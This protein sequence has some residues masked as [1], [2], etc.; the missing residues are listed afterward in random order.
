V[1]PL[2]LELTAFG[3]YER[4]QAID[5]TALGPSELFL[6]HGPTG[7]GKTTLFDGLTYALFG[8]LAGTRGVD[9]L[10][11][12]RAPADLPTRVAFRFRLGETAYRVERTPEWQR[13]KKRGSGTTTE[14]ATASLWREGEAKP[15]ATGASDT[16][17]AVAGL[18]GMGV[19]QF[20][21]VAL[22]P[23]GEFKRLLCATTDEREALLQQLFATHRYAEVEDL[24]VG[25]KRELESKASKLKERRAEVLGGDAEEGLATAL[26]AAEAQVAEAS[27]GDAARQAEDRDAEQALAAARALAGRFEEREAARAADGRAR[28]G[29][30]ALSAD[31]L[32]LQRAEAAE[33]ARQRLEAARR[34]AEEEGARRREVAGGRE[35]L[36]AADRALAAAAEAARAAEAEAPERARLVARAQVLERALPEVERLVRLD[37]ELATASAGAAAAAAG[38][39]EAG[40]RL[41]AAERRPVELEEEAS[42]LRPLA[43][44]AAPRAEALARLERAL[45]AA[46]ERDAAEAASAVKAKEVAEAERAAA[47]ARE[48]AGRAEQAASALNAAREGGLAAWLAQ[49]KL[50]PGK[51]CPVCGATDHPAP[52]TAA[53]HVPDKE[54]VDQA[55][56]EATALSARAAAAE[57]TRSRQAGL[58][59]DLRDRAATLAAAEP[60]PA[61]ALRAEGDA[62]ARAAAEAREAGRR[63]AALEVELDSAR[64][65]VETARARR[66]R[67][68]AAEAAARDTAGRAEAARTE[69]ARQLEQAG[70]GPGAAAELGAL[71]A[72]LKAAE[73]RAEGARAGHQ[74]ATAGQ[75]EA[76]TRLAAA[77]TVRERAAAAAAEAS[78]AAQAACQAEGFADLAACE[79]ALLAPPA[80]QALAASVEA[81]ATEAHAAADRLATLERSLG[82]QSPPDLTAA[83]AARQA[84]AAR[85]REAVAARAR[86]GAE[87]A[88][89]RER[90]DRLAALGAEGAE[91]EA[92]LSVVG[93]VAELTRGRNERGM[94][95]SRFVL[96]A[97]LEEVALAA[98]ARLH[99]MSRGRFRL[100]QDDSV[101]RRNSA[102]GLSL[103]VEDA[104]TGVADRPVGAL[105]GG[106]SFLA[107]LSLALGLSDV[108]LQRS[109][110]RRLDALFVDEGF[111]TLDEA[112]LDVAIQALATLR[113]AGRLVGVI[114]HVPELRRRIAARIEVRATETGSVAVVHPA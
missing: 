111:G 75:V 85:V 24:L 100:R 19:D 80:R 103:V 31:R 88:R 55:R 30:A 64:A 84:V 7:S 99:V 96:A 57:A 38:R 59:A 51:P 56:A 39:E 48:A 67:D 72:R 89:L 20:T 93:R 28:A 45:E 97:R 65:A 68:A 110:G 12:D 25:R 8:K 106:E 9:R 102:A 62:A 71:Q 40:R 35:A 108:V 73:A 58:L 61:A 105:S 3:P 32:R 50:Q 60:R 46:R 92:T 54:H 23:Q 2:Q 47:A 77:E 33:R 27:A 49:K 17:D 109:G 10:R 83:Q 43:A 90:L 94:S 37:R 81:R 107:S 34:A 41:A 101:A 113:Q 87:V 98:S 22:L 66:D 112:T 4:Q 21:Q 53:G 26:A 52:A 44:D 78:A 95:L 5:F 36:A 104:W 1:R 16:T 91:V 82:G 79:A 69:L 42:R 70:A 63:L 86:L 15:L 13:P 29:A 6:I 18:L 74:R 14:P 11:A 114:S 76:A